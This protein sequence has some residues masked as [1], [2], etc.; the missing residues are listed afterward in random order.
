MLS[1]DTLRMQRVLIPL[2]AGVL[3]I[4]PPPPRTP[5][6]STCTSSPD[7]VTAPSAN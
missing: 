5:T 6:A 1:A 3:L 7:S 2:L 4:A